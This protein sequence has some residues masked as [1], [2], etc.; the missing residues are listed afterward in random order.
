MPASISVPAGRYEIRTVQ[1]AS[2]L[3]RSEVDIKP[4]SKVTLRVEK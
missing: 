3:S 4:S 2:V 1:G